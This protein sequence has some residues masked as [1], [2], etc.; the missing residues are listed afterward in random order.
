M[1]VEEVVFPFCF[2][3][4]PRQAFRASGE[5]ARRAVLLPAAIHDHQGLIS[6]LVR[7]EGSHVEARALPGVT[8]AAGA[9]WRTWLPWSSL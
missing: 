6:D 1:V 2:I 8:S 5:L 4:L 7:A 3:F 9:S